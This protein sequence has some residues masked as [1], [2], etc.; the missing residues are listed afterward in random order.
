[1][2]STSTTLTQSRTY[3]AVVAVSLALAVC[4]K[5][6]TRTHARTHE[7]VRNHTLSV[8][9][10]A[11]A[12]LCQS[13][14]CRWRLQVA[15]HRT[16]VPSRRR[17]RH[18]EAVNAVRPE[19]PQQSHRAGVCVGGCCAGTAAKDSRACRYTRR[20]AACCFAGDQVYRH[21]LYCFGGYNG[22]SVL[23]DFYEYRFEPVVVLPS[24]LKSDLLSLVNNKTL[25]WGAAT[26]C[27]PL[28]L[29]SVSTSVLWLLCALQR[30][31]VHC[32]RQARLCEVLCLPACTHS[33]PLSY[34]LSLSLS[35]SFFLLSSY[36]GNLG[37]VL[38][39]YS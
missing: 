10:C 29:P 37:R 39:Q 13:P 18:V 15:V 26:L 2:T 3:L 14:L 1:M 8:A 11:T 31:D 30:R 20:D 12:P 25:R 17:G 19:R 6:R 22:H 9:R 7:H 38:S 35:L 27:V 36:P 34:S 16:G 24:T 21:S 28:V 4:H 23:N 33:L 5:T 32:R